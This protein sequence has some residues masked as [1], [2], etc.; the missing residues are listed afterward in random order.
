[1]ISNSKT[2]L[3]IRVIDGDMD[4]AKFVICNEWSMR[5]GDPHICEVAYYNESGQSCHK[6]PV[7]QHSS[8]IGGFASST[9]TFT[10]NSGSGIY[11]TNSKTGDR[12]YLQGGYLNEI[13]YAPNTY[14][15][16][17]HNYI[18]GATYNWFKTISTATTTDS[19]AWNYAGNWTNGAPA[20]FRFTPP[21]GHG[22]TTGKVILLLDVFAACK[23]T[24]V[25]CG[26][27]ALVGLTYSEND[28]LYYEPHAYRSND[29]PLIRN[30]ENLVC[31]Q[32]AIGRSITIFS[33][34][35][36]VRNIQSIDI[37]LAIDRLRTSTVSVPYLSFR[38]SYILG[39]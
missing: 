35:P 10:V 30:M 5:D 32:A 9:T 27:N 3:P 21:Y 31:G 25:P 7:A 36:A 2:A 22:Y 13:L 4:Q 28:T 20:T 18:S 12:V 29:S 33:E 1:M 37:T 8:I 15:N 19:N 24:G 14:Q 26:V 38:L 6:N 34:D 17:Y 23:T 39:Y 11:A 16:V